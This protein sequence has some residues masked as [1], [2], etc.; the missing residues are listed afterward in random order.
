MFC[1]ALRFMADFEVLSE[2]NRSNS[3]LFRGFFERRTSKD[4]VKMRC[5]TEHLL[6]DGD[7]L[8]RLSDAVPIKPLAW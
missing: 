7:L 6:F 1:F 4:A 3:K 2:K 5:K 8:Q